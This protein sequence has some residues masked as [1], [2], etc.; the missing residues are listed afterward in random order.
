MPYY[1]L[2]SHCQTNL[3]PPQRHLPPVAPPR[4]Q[5]DITAVLILPPPN[6]GVHI[7]PPPLPLDHGCR[8]ALRPTDS[9]VQIAPPPLPLDHGRRIALRP[10]DSFCQCAL[11]S[12]LTTAS[13]SGPLL[14]DPTA[15]S[16]SR[17]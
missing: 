8:I 3:S 7:A 2:R 9:F 16:L 4:W 17:C 12:D 1:R 6:P 10:T 13:P 5:S 11:L 15:T 14:S